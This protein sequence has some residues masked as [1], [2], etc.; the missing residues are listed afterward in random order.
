MQRN[1]Q[2]YSEKA[3]TLTSISNNCYHRVRVLTLT[4]H[5]VSMMEKIA[6]NVNSS[7]GSSC[8]LMCILRNLLIHYPTQPQLMYL[9]V[10]AKHA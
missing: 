3:R 2:I 8:T 1:Y 5:V 4:D 9:V 7:I 10:S 6:V